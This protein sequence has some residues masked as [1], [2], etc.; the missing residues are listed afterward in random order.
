M[1]ASTLDLTL[2]PTISTCSRCS[3][4]SGVCRHVFKENE[5]AV[6]QGRKPTH[7]RQVHPWFTAFLAGMIFA[8]VQQSLGLE[9]PWSGVSQAIA[10]VVV[11]YVCVIDT[12]QR[13]AKASQ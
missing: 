1:G 8:W 12:S 9:L 11:G 13:L 6:R 5:Q 10:E 7:D 2:A 4:C 3:G